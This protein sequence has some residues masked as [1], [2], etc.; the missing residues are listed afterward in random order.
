MSPLPQL[1]PRPNQI[2]TLR[3]EL[4]AIEAKVERL[5]EAIVQRKTKLNRLEAAAVLN[6]TSDAPVSPRHG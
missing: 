1:G 4:A 6:G 2:A 5:K 3:Q